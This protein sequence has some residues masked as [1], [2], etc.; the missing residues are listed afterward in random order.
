MDHIDILLVNPLNRRNKPAYIPYGILYIAS[1]LLKK[2]V[3]VK[4]FDRNA[5]IE[6]FRDA[7]ERYTPR[8]VGFSVLTGPTVNDAVDLSKQVRRLPNEP[9]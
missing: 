6:S 7:L 4:I 9:P 3:K 5:E 1:Y 8:V 2:D